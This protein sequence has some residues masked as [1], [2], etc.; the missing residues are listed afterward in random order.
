[1]K[2]LTFLSLSTL[3]AFAN[4]GNKQNNNPQTTPIPENMKNEELP[5]SKKTVVTG[6]NEFANDLL[7]N[8]LNSEDQKGKNIF[9]SSFS[10]YSA[11]AMTSEGAN[12]QTADQMQKVLHLP[13]DATLKQTEM[14]SL[15]IALNPTTLD[16]KLSV[17]NALWA[18]KGY[19]FLPEFTSVNTTSYQAK[20]E[21]LDFFQQPEA[22]LKT[23]NS[24]VEDK[25]NNKIKNLLAPSNISKATRLILTNAVYF[26]A[27]WAEPFEAEY[28]QEKEFTTASAGK[29][30]AQMMLQVKGRN[31]AETNEAQIVELPY[32]GN[33]LSMIIVLPKKGQT[34]NSVAAVPSNFNQKGKGEFVRV[35]L[36]KFKLEAKYMMKDDLTKMGMPTPFS[37][38]ADF[39]GMSDNTEGL[40]IGQIIHQTFVEVNETGTEAAAATAVS[41]EAGSAP[42]KPKEF[43]A[44]RPFIFMIRHNTTGAILFTGVLND[45]TKN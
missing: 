17:A 23:I 10:V 43:L 22:A 33:E 38:K 4:C 26:K 45:P 41:M 40:F 35:V 18:Q 7:T 27:D 30:K 19:S 13:V 25:T 6:N 44:D 39:S 32:K 9:F 21:N 5:V 3:F 28:T 31:Y 12:G 24:W 20:I 2:R 42:G 1:M 11:L 15:T 16:Y 36:P 14:N 37:D 8:Y 29:V 34:V